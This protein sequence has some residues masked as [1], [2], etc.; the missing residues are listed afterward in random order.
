MK[1]LIMGLPGSGK[2]TLANALVRHLRE[3]GRQV[4]WWNAD[5]VR[6][7]INNHL[8]FS[9]E[10]RLQQARTM[11]WLS[12]QVSRAGIVGVVDFVCPTPEARTAYCESG[13]P[14][15]LVWLNN[16]KEG[17]FEN[18]NRIF[19]PPEKPDVIIDYFDIIPEQRGKQEPDEE[20]LNKAD[21]KSV[22]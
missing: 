13:P 16:I 17:R 2:T 12:N 21:R 9:V 6:E 20:A 22:V 14:D 5:E 1:I 10:D 7:I 8:G 19:V 11:G 15:V 4:V 3:T 18:T